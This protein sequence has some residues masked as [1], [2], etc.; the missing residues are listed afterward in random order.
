MNLPKR[1]WIFVATAPIFLVAANSWGQASVPPL[2]FLETQSL[3]LVVGEGDV[4]V[5]TAILKNATPSSVKMR[6]DVFMQGS[7]GMSVSRNPQIFLDPESLSPGEV[8][9]V[10]IRIVG[11]KPGVLPMSGQIVVQNADVV[12][13][14]PAFRTVRLTR[15]RWTIASV[16][17]WGSLAVAV[18]VS[19]IVGGL[20]RVH[21]GSHMG[22]PTWDF[23][24]SWASNITLGG[25][26][27]IP[28]VV[29]ATFPEQTQFVNKTGYTVL[30]LFFGA[31]SAAA[32]LFYKCVPFDPKSSSSDTD[33]SESDGIVFMFL[34]AS[35][36]T[37]WGACAQVATLCLIL[38]EIFLSRSI[39]ADVLVGALVFLGLTILCL[40][41][42]AAI[43][44]YRTVGAQIGDKG[45]PKLTT[46]RFAVAPDGMVTARP[47]IAEPVSRRWSLM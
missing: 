21:L 28:A 7:N 5:G 32:P 6:S 3:P 34:I 33:T 9:A 20:L 37:L 42:Y 24:K 40:S 18:L 27:A 11:L 23:T 26:I 43:T 36:L 12:Q 35:G 22:S 1:L 39:S 45:G 19:L 17:F 14:L 41:V 31:L 25:A 47:D 29:F 8:R 38:G 13:G 4:A 2:I 10:T 15:S 16:L 46:Y 44:M 30:G